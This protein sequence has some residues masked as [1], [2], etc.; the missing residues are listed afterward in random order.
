M[1]HKKSAD[2]KIHILSVGYQLISKNGFTCTGLA[3]LLKEAN[4]PKGSFYHYF[5]SKEEFG[6]SLI[7]YYFKKYKENLSKIE[8]QDLSAKEKIIHYFTSWKNNQAIENNTNRCL[9]VKLSAEI[10]DLSETMRT[11]LYLGYQ[12]IIQ[13]ITNRIKEAQESGDIS[14]NIDAYKMACHW[15]Y[16]WLGAGIIAK[17]SNSNHPLED[18]WHETIHPLITQ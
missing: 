1:K 13:W 10:S 15:Y 7:E 11:A 12:E 8:V 5:S 2:T 3:Q 6:K 16:A 18:I 14:T 9:V 4:I 17:L